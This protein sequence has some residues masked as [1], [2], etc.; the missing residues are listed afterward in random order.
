MFYFLILHLVSVS[1]IDSLVH[2]HLGCQRCCAWCIFC[3]LSAITSVL[4]LQ[5]LFV[6]LAASRSPCRLVCGD[7]DS[8]RLS[9]M[10]FSSLWSPHASYSFSNVAFSGSG[11][12]SGFSELQYNFFKT[13]QKVTYCVKVLFKMTNYNVP[14]HCRETLLANYSPVFQSKLDEMLLR[15]RFGV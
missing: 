2:P 13:E 14:S 11:S 3:V 7:C 8:V 9:C 15:A 12:E 6:M 5:Y 10:L 4:L 1:T